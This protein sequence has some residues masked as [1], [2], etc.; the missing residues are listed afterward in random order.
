[1]EVENPFSPGYGESPP[2]MAGRDDVLNAAI[3]A[4]RRGPGRADYHCILIGPRGSGKTTTL[5]AIAELA[6]REHGVVI[7]RWTAGSR[8]LADAVDVGAR[9]ADK[10]LRSRWRRAGAGVDPSA[11]VGVPGVASASAS[12]RRAEDEPSTFAR[13]NGWPYSARS[14]IG[15]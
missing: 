12:R 1:M 8:T 3:V 10:Q 6:A 14:A 4:L 15:R 5:N 9:S 11:T 13:S 2:Y 7:V